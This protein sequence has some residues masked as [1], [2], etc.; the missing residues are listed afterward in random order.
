MILTF[1][2]IIRNNFHC[3]GC[4][5]IRSDCGFVTDAHVTK[6]ESGNCIN[7]NRDVTSFTK[8]LSHCITSQVVKI[9]GITCRPPFSGD[10]INRDRDR[11]VK[12]NMTVRNSPC[13]LV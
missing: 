11:D 8:L 1:S 10:V 5:I 7:T 12:K 6:M 3:L 13:Q 9:N 2:V 4:Y